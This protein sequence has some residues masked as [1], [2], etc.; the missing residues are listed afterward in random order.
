MAPPPPF[1]FVTDEKPETRTKAALYNV[2]SSRYQNY[3]DF[4]QLMATHKDRYRSG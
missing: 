4:Y 3:L 2:R 1:P